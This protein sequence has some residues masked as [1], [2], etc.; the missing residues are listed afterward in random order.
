[1]VNIPL[2]AETGYTSIF[3][4]GMDVSNNGV[5]LNLSGNILSNPKTVSWTSAVQLS[6][7]K[8]EIKALPN[9]LTE[10]V[11]GDNKLKV[12]ESVGAFWLYANKGIYASNADVPVNPNTYQKQ[13][14]NGISLKAGDPRWADTNGDYT[15]NEDDK[16]FAGD[17]M[18]KF[19]GG[20]TN[21]FQYKNFDLNVHLFFALGQK[22][23]N[24][25]D[26]KRYDFINT[27]SAKDINSVKEITSWQSHDNLRSYPIY[28]VWSNVAPYRTDQDLFLEDASYVKLRS[29]TLGYD[30]AQSKFAARKQLGFRRAYIYVTGS[31]L[32]TLTKFSGNDPE[33]VSFN[34]IYDGTGMPIARTFVLGL[35]LEL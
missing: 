19:L 27:E 6:Y 30:L 3:K 7:N 32:L 9:G 28:N 24:Q 15:I 4:N 14:F 8:N 16:I 2:A 11:I 1:L 35:K 17:R 10:L 13:T 22:A 12:G 5:E 26:A 33:T 18:P 31:N 34:G 25:F 23:I 21:H 20:W 29:V